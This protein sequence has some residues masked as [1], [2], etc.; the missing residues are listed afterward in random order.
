MGRKAR[1]GSQGTGGLCAR[2]VHGTGLTL[3]TIHAVRSHDV[4]ITIERPE[5]HLGLFK[6]GSHPTPGPPL[7][8]TLRAS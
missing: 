2:Q 6:R 5:G 7:S 3:R 1:T 8:P 4:P